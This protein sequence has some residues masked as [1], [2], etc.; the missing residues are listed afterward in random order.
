[1]LHSIAADRPYAVVGIRQENGAKLPEG[2]DP[3]SITYAEIATVH[4]FGSADGAIPERS[5][6]R[7]AFDENREKISKALERELLK[8]VDDAVREGSTRLVYRALGR[9]GARVTG[10]VQ[11]KIRNGPFVPNAPMTIARKKSDKPLI[12]TGRLRQ[13]I[14][15]EVRKR[16][17][18]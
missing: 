18:E 10:M 5:F 17:D 11:A 14:D 7:S 15:F 4:E 12:D 8:I 13:S 1:M 2:A 3:G 16:G 9:V 6:L